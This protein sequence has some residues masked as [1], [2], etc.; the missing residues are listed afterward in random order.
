M[1]FN[2]LPEKEPVFNESDSVRK[3]NNILIV[4]DDPLQIEILKKGFLSKSDIFQT[5]I[6]SSVKETLKN[7]ASNPPDLILTDWI[8][9][10]GKG[11]DILLNKEIVSNFPVIV[12]TSFGDEKL[13]V[14]VIKAGAIDYLAKSPEM[15][16]EIPH[17]VERALREWGA[18]CRKNE[19]DEIARNARKH[20][21]DVINFLPDPVLAIDREGHVIVWNHALELLTGVS[22][23]K[24]LGKGNHEYSIPIYG[25]RRPLLIDL[26]LKANPETE[27]R[28]AYIHHFGDRIMAETFVPAL[29][30]GRGAYLWGIATPLYDSAGNLIGAIEAIRDITER[31]KSEE[32]LQERETRFHALIQNSS[33]IIRILNRDG[34]ITYESE[35]GQRILGY[36]QSYFIGKIPL[37]YVHPEDLDRVKADLKTIFENTHQKTPTEFRIRKAD[38]TYLWVNSIGINLFGVPGIDGIVVTIRPIQEQKEL[39]LQ[40][41]QSE[42]RT[43]LALEG[44]DVAFWDWNLPTG[45]VIFSDRFYTMLGYTPAEFP[46]DYENWTRQIHP[47]DREQVL[48]DL[49]TQIR[50]HA[51]LCET[52][53]R[54]KRKDGNWSWILERGKIVESDEKG[55]ATRLTGVLIDITK[56]KKMED[57]ILTLNQVLEQRVLERTEMLNKSLQEKEILLREIHHRVKNNL[58]IIISLIRLQKNLVHDMPT[59]N[60]LL[61][62]ESRIRSMALVHE[63]LYRS[64]DLATIPMGEY[65]RTLATTL[66]STYSLNPSRIQ[67]SIDMSDLLFD[68]NTAIPVGLILNELITNTFK[69]AFPEG[70]EGKIEILGSRTQSSII[71][72]VRDNGVGLP[73][74]LNPKEITSLGLHLVQ[75]LTE[76]LQGTLEIG[77]R[78]GE[79]ASFVITFPR[80]DQAPFS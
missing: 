35:S 2:R 41:I 79:G 72:T 71:L 44:A 55:E 80:I 58:Q 74:D 68:I 14:E 56:R 51:A 46:A 6:V 18:I 60:V 78:A 1:Y 30:N 40:L 75:T 70:F 5:T 34:R 76:Q 64:E 77:G 57:E 27:K 9:P 26:V 36:P 32:A 42:E 69:H 10:D 49:E 61:D 65:V 12:M 59:R 8:L 13:A 53:F 67:I 54:M 20:L 16:R 52:E 19:C 43:R 48:R 73:P 66:I 31:K 22:A 4:E 37:D 29:L 21:A 62:S 47:E 24:V 39:E 50:A 3:K 63:K 11:S 33:D 25:E 17:I 23:E 38:S 45:N 28:Y 15:Y 7:I